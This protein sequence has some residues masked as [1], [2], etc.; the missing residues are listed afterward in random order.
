MAKSSDVRGT[1]RERTIDAMEERGWKVPVLSRRAGVAESTIYRLLSDDPEFTAST[2]TLTRLSSALGTQLSD[3]GPLDLGL[4]EEAEPF[5]YDATKEFNDHVKAFVTPRPATD[6]WILRTR[7]LTGFG[8]MP[9]D[10]VVLDLNLEW[11]AGD[12]VCA[13][14][15]SHEA[16]RTETI[17]RRYEPPY[18][19]AGSTDPAF[20][21]PIHEDA[22]GRKGVVVMTYRPRQRD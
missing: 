3:T 1:I 10:V 16:G 7:A 22:V 14:L 20:V 19:V 13:Q 8:Y 21:R 18:L 17:W 11:Q 4:S 9:G 5:R 6:P 2:R 12:I 15:Y